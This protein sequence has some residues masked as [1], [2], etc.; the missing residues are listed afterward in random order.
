ME[1]EIRFL[2]RGQLGAFINHVDM[3][4]G[5][6]FTKCPYYYI[7]IPYLLKWS[8][9]GEGIK[10]ESPN[11]EAILTRRKIVKCLLVC[12][13]P[14]GN[15]PLNYKN[16]K[17]VIDNYWIKL[18]VCCSPASGQCTCKFSSLDGIIIWEGGNI[19]W[20]GGIAKNANT[21]NGK[22]VAKYWSTAY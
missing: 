18:L 16:H 20:V 11:D 12:C 2:Y 8:K 7:R 3:A 6:G 17:Y 10:N 13:L 9:K 21:K 15:A 5:G 19:I 4:E 14:P 1:K 22:S